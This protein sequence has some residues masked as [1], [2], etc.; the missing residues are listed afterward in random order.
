MRYELR[1]VYLLVIL[2]AFYQPILII[3]LKCLTHLILHITLVIFRKSCMVFEMV[4]QL[5][6]CK[7]GKVTINHSP[8]T[9][10]R[11]MSLEETQFLFNA[12]PLRRYRGAMPYIASSLPSTHPGIQT[13][14]QGDCPYTATYN[15]EQACNRIANQLDAKTD[16]THEKVSDI[17]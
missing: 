17:F 10:E 13:T 4:W 3:F 5:Q 15:R 12:R 1:N 14:A 6:A 7:R 2:Y 8:T 16:S 9:A 11:G